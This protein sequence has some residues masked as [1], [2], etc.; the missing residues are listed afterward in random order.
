MLDLLICKCAA[1]GREGQSPLSI[2]KSMLDRDWHTSLVE[3]GVSFL[4][5]LGRRGYLPMGFWVRWLSI[6]ICVV[7]ELNNYVFGSALYG[8]E[9]MFSSDRLRSVSFLGMLSL[10][11]VFTYLYHGS[12]TP[13]PFEWA[14]LGIGLI[15]VSWIHSIRRNTLL[16]APV[17]PEICWSGYFAQLY[18]KSEN[19]GIDKAELD[20]NLIEFLRSD[21]P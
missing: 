8:V 19:G 9:M 13:S 11:P 16:Q 17:R 7:H 10:H 18:E 4:I 14:D 12:L 15:A 21:Y 20:Q 3:L 5:S 2:E 1:T 6:L